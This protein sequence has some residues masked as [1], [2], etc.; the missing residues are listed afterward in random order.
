MQANL[1]MAVMG[2]AWWLRRRDVVTK[3]RTRDKVRA[4]E[5][6][7]QEEKEKRIAQLA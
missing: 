7:K 1:M 6:K 5:A 2:Q 3:E 4:A